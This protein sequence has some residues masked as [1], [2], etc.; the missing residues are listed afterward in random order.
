LDSKK[1]FFMNCI[2]LGN[3][4]SILRGWAIFGLLAVSM[5]AGAAGLAAAD[6]TVPAGA[7]AYVVAAPSGEVV[8]SGTSSLH[9]WTVKSNAIDGKAVITLPAAGNTAATPAIESIHLTIAVNSLHSS[10]GSG[11]DSTV[12]DSLNSSQNPTITYD[13]TS[14]KLQA[15]PAGSGK[16]WQFATVGNLSVA[17]K[18]HPVNMT[19]DLTPGVNGAQVITTEVKMNMTDFAVQPPTAMLGMIH[20]GDAITVDA[21]WN[22]QAGVPK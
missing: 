3:R 7:L 13:L 16:D 17:G 11:M 19:L 6:S 12:Y 20:S 18:T 9:N 2:K 1:E 8:I 14:A 5:A 21:T 22:L 10:E 4:N 15:S